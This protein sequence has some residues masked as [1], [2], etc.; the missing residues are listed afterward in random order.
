[1]KNKSPI[2]LNCFSRGGSNILW[3]FFLSHPSVLHPTEETIQIFNTTFRAPRLEG[4]KI[5]MMENRF[6]FRQWKFKEINPVNIE[7]ARYI[8]TILFNKKMKNLQD[9]GAK[10]I[11]RGHP[12][13]T[14]TS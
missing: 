12:V 1:M 3:N 6:V 8:D 14:G 5:V 2:I 13:T 7:T 11:I 4:Y 9:S 10:K